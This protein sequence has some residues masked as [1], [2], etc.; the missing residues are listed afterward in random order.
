M[1]FQDYYKLLG[2][3][4]SVSD[5]ELKKAYR[6]LAR[7][8]HPDVSKEADAEE[9]FKQVKEA[10]EVLKDPEKRKFY[11]QYGEHWKQ[12]QQGGFAGG[13]GSGFGGGGS[14]GFGAGGFTGADAGDFSDFF[15]NMFGGGGGGFRYSQG[16]GG[17][18]YRARGEDLHSK[19]TVSLNDAFK[20]ATR[21]L[22]LQVPEA[23]ARGQVVSKLKTLNVKIPKGVTEG[24]QIRLAGQGGPG[25][26]GAPNGDLYLEIEFEKHPYFTLQGKDVYYRLP[27]T[28]WEAALG[29]KITVPLVEGKV[30]LTIPVGSE[31]GKKMRLKGKGLPAKIPGD[32]YVVLDIV[33]PTPE[34]A[35]QKAVYETMAKEFKDFNPRKEVA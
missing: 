5:A 1:E 26:G 19:V 20:G 22:R 12:A 11:D 14:S 21:S 7:K 17:R 9:K 27:I 33:T 2:V 28:P 4:K 8:Y 16:G 23:N 34:T 3:S 31:S 10:Y 24:Q 18:A 13:A 15:E 6:K 35:M 32:F 30:D 25:E 29:N